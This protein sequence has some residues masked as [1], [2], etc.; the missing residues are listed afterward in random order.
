MRE[1]FVKNINWYLKKEEVEAFFFP[2]FGELKFK[3]MLSKN[4]LFKGMGIL[5]IDSNIDK[6]LIKQLNGI[7]LAGRNLKLQEK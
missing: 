3:P 2:F 6:E 5:E 1:L 7:E 4:K